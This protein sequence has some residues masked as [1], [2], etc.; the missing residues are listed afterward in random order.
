M[1]GS[2]IVSAARMALATIL[3]H[4][5]R[6]FLT[7]LGVIIGTGTVIAVS[8]LITGVDAVVANFMASLG[9]DTAILFKFNIGFRGAM[10]PEEW[11]RKPLTWENAQAI[12]ERCPSVIH[13]SAFLFSPNTFS[14]RSQDRVRYK[15]EEVYRIQLGGTDES[16]VAGGAERMIY[17]RFFTD[18][19]S[20]RRRPVVVIGEDVQKGLFPTGDPVG[21]WIDVNGRFFEVIGVMARPTASPPGHE[22]LRVLLP[23]FTMRKMFPQAKEHMIIVV[24]EKGKLTKA[25]DEVRAVLRQE[26]RVPYNKPDDFWMSTGQQMLEDFRNI[27]ST[28]AVVMVVLSSIGLLVGGIG[29][30][31]IMLVSVTERTR[32]IGIRKA[33][34]AKRTDIV[35]Q[36]LTEAVVLTGLGGLLGMSFGWFVSTVARLAFPILPTA[37]P[38]WAA[39]TGVLV[40]VGVGLFFGI[41]PAAKAARLDPVVALR[42][43]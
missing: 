6:S 29:V 16:Y 40:S 37:V 15:G 11:K 34:G 38:L 30:M 3:E 26:R 35:A 19:E 18:D 5:M 41:W 22:D 28:V 13:V 21:K 32:E 8:S 43:E 10:T 23:Y 4:K 9:P 27:T 20:R 25:L 36:F 14:G 39:A 1:S 17:G 12:K 33:I 24:A 42:Y 31:N 7:V 2:E